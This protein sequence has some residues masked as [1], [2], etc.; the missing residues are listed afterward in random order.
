M[1]A[2]RSVRLDVSVPDFRAGLGTGLGGT[3]QGGTLPEPDGQARQRFE[4]ALGA[5]DAPAPAAAGAPAVAVPQPF[6]LF[7]AAASAP[8]RD[9]VID[10]AVTD[11]VVQALA[12]RDGSQGN[13]QVRIE[14]KD[15]AFPGV[16]VTVQELEGRLQVDFVC[17]VEPSRLR[18]AEGAPQHAATLAQR[19]AREVLVRVQ[20][21]DIE[22]PCLV[23]ALGTPT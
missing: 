6:A 8:G 15:E 20:T 19:L 5:G 16:S 2:E 9:A 14:L 18:L 11:D 21:D 23:Q 13:A 17:A 3:G 12:V 1:S 4:A 22:D 7:G 10:P